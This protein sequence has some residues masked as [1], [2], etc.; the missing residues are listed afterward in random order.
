VGFTVEE[1]TPTE[2]LTGNNPGALI[3]TVS[4]GYFQTMEIPVLMG[5]ALLDSDD[6]SA[7]G[8]AL[9]NEAMAKQ[10]WPGRSALGQR[11][12]LGGP[13]STNDWLT[14]VG[15]VG[16][17]RQLDLREEPRPE[18]YLPFGQPHPG[19]TS[20]RAFAV[21]GS[22]DALTLAGSLR[23]AIWTVDRSLPVSDVRSMNVVIGGTLAELRLSTVLLGLLGATSLALAA[24]GV[25]G[26]MSFAVA[27][28][29]REMGLRIALGAS[30]SG[31]VKM[32][33]GQA[34]MLAAL[35][36]A[37]GVGGALALGRL[38][39]AQLYGMTPTDPANV[40]GSALVLV[41]A[42]TAASVVPALRAAR[43]SAMESMRRDG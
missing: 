30:P 18:W 27:Q 21:R 1:P 15:V 37:L 13:Q 8:V 22:G 16:D 17:V 41:L 9:V 31:I 26:V 28:R 4:S 10:F 35:G 33:L 12:K 19:F 34:L 23:E 5:R 20:P 40:T 39:S 25:Y 29:Q 42:A 2:Q 38:L 32:V 24:L 7:P 6:A 43:A 14:V 3:R 11:I 36:V